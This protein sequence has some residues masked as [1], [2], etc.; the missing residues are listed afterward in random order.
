MPNNST[1]N[2]STFNNSTDP[3]INRDNPVKGH[4]THRRILL[5]VS[6]GIAAYKSAELIRRLR[7]LGADVRVI[8]TRAAQ[9]FITPL[10][11]QAL[12]ANPV[13]TDLLDP[14][15]EAAMGHIELA[16]WA[17]LMVIAP[18][19]ADIVSRLAQG[20]GDDLL[21]TVCL[22]RRCPLAVAP[23]MNQAMWR[24]AATRENIKVLRAR[25]VRILGPASGT[26]ACGDTGY[27]RMSDPGELAAGISGLFE[28]RLLTGK[29]VVVTAGPTREALDPV[30]YLSNRSSG[31]MGY[32]VARAAA[33][34]GAE[35][36]L[37]SGPTALAKPEQ[38]TSVDVISAEE[39]LTACLTAAE[40]CD[41]F[42]AAAAVADYRPMEVARHK[43]KKGREDT[44]TMELVK[45]PDIVATVAA[46]ATTAQPRP[47]IVGFA[48]ET[49]QVLEYARRKLERK[50]LDLIVANDVSDPAI[51][52]DSERN[53]VVLLSRERQ[54]EL[55]ENSSCNWLRLLLNLLPVCS[56]RSA[57]ESRLLC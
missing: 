24:N 56:P 55:P 50:N 41:I 33:E 36:V 32:A 1:S 26:Q 16:R 45:N 34:A 3:P 53:K 7:E 15:A 38:V 8:M 47:F 6:G 37:I 4:L 27:G 52:F 9:E 48:A 44:M 25:D 57:I 23:A 43:I 51:G 20:K 31:R 40:S 28:S 11:L 39:M 14:Q 13:H 29:R 18:A 22:A 12:S 10:T 42:I 17:D 49:Q 30:R 19:S 46:R 5:G 21:T 35:V 2:N 54:I